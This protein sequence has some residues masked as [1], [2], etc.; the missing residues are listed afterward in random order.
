MQTCRYA[1]TVQCSMHL[2]NLKIKRCTSSA[3]VPCNQQLLTFKCSL[4]CCSATAAA[5]A[6]AAAGAAAGSLLLLA[7]GR[8][9]LRVNAALN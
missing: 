9:A 2:P 5:A 3:F 1:C 8:G 6:A 7:G 4:C